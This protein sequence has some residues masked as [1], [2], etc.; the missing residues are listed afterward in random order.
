MAGAA[1]AGP[2]VL[3]RPPS[4]PSACGTFRATPASAPLP[5]LL[6]AHPLLAQRPPH[7]PFYPRWCAV[8]WWGGVRGRRLLGVGLLGARGAA[9]RGYSPRAGGGGW[10]GWRSAAG[11]AAVVSAARG[12]LRRGRPVPLAVRRCR[13]L[14]WQ[15]EV[16]SALA[17]SR[18]SGRAVCSVWQAWRRQRDESAGEQC[19]GSGGGFVLAT[20]R[21]LLRL[22][23]RVGGPRWRAAVKRLR[24]TCAAGELESEG[25]PIG[26]SGW[27]AAVAQAGLCTV[28]QW[29]RAQSSAAVAAQGK[30]AAAR[31]RRRQDFRLPGPLAAV[32]GGSRGGWVS[33]WGWWGP[34]LQWVRAASR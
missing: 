6:T 19:H 1:S 31:V 5:R 33:S 13:F 25:A 34:E 28:L 32:G 9:W 3:C 16:L 30:R 14:Q 18:Q 24:G 26:G 2:V 22:G 21:Q 4:P 12:E 15:A 27:V 8:C 17:G 29:I 7:R 10:A 11:Q 23:A 20:W